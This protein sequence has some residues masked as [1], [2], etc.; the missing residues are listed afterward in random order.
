MTSQAPSVGSTPVRL[1]YLDLHAA[2]LPTLRLDA[3]LGREQNR[4]WSTGTVGN[5]ELPARSFAA[6]SIRRPS[7]L[8]SQEVLELPPFS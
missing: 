4:S 2:C 3:D 6:T 5:S 8:D 7:Y 1:D